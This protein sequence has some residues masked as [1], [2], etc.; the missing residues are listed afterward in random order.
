MDTRKLI[1]NVSKEE[2]IKNGFE[3]TSLRDIAKKCYISPAAIYRHFLN[4]EDIYNEITKPL[5]DYFDEIANI[6]SNVDYKFLMDK[7]PSNV[8]NFEQGGNFIFEFLFGKYNDLVRLIVKERKEWFKNYLVNFEFHTSIK[9][10]EEMEKN[11]FKINKYNKNAF[12]VILDSYIEAYI[13]LLDL[14]EGELEEAC[15]EINNFYTIGFRNLF[16]F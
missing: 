16:G 7:N 2:F 14:D 12:R 15:R 1:L 5:F 8:W 11:D 6:V 4:K 9:Y 10:F 3:N 13:N